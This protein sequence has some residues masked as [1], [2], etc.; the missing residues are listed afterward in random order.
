MPW[1]TSGPVD[2][3]LQFIA[4]AQ[5][6]PAEPFSVLCAR[7]GI[8]RKT[9]Y[10][11]VER[12]N[13]GGPAT[14]L[15]RPSRPRQL[16]HATPVALVARILD[17]RRAHPRW[18]PKKLRAL[19]RAQDPALP[20]PAAS[21]VGDLLK[22]HGLIVPRRRRIRWTTP[23]ADRPAPAGPNDTWCVDFK[24]DFALGDGTRCY[25][26]TVT[27]LHS[28]YLLG[29]TCLRS[30]DGEP[31]RTAFER[32]FALYGLPARIRSD[33]GVPFATTA[34]GGLSPLAIGWIKRG[35]TLERTDPGHP[36]QNGAHERMHRTMKDDTTKPP[37]QD[38]AAQQVRLDRFRREY[39][40]LRP[41]ESLGQTTPASHYSPSLRAAPAVLA[42]PTYAEDW[43]T[44]RVGA[45]GKIELRGRRVCLHAMLT[46]ERVGLE[47][48][49]EHRWA[50]FFGPVRLGV[51]DTSA[52]KPR[53]QPSPREPSPLALPTAS[54][55]A[56]PLT[57]SPPDGGTRVPDRVE[58]PSGS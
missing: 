15:D 35:I 13:A 27:D 31:V 41:H 16:A 6:E 34:P 20:W 21:T 47:P 24:G 57:T 38:L 56:R 1:K 22:R 37:E 44:L 50:V 14:L 29:V 33:N 9:G 12:Y 2:Q 53:L 43:R 11:W 7:F 49:E 19:L 46:G 30:V 45:Q 10:K 55:G 40:E 48:L 28:R 54:P 52:P 5:V 26:L 58:S 36:E 39:N 25:P 17:A 32:L 42:D 18:G 8:S 51:I 3:R 4:A 23:R